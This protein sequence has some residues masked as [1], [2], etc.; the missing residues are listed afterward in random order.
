M[1]TWAMSVS[2]T[3]CLALVSAPAYADD[4]DEKPIVTKMRFV[5]RA[6]D[7]TAYTNITA[8][9]DGAT[10][11]NL[12]NGFPSTVVAASRGMTTDCGAVCVWILATTD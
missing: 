12:E 9:F 2:L 4:D 10:Y 3:C 6:N 7:L 8:L 1:R 11:N 5:E